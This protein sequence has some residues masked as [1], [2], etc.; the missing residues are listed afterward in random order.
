MSPSGGLLIVNADDWGYD[1]PTTEAIAECF[2]AGG[3]TS[4]T[5]MSFMAGSDFAAARARRHPRLGIGLHLNL[6][7]EYSDPKVPPAV[8]DRQKRLIEYSR[9]LRLR[10]WVYDPSSRHQVNRVIADQ[11][12]R[13]VD[14]YGRMPTHLDGHHHC[15]LAANVLISPAVPTGMKIRNALE[16]KHLRNPFT[17]GLRWMRARMISR[18]FTTTDRFLSVETFWPDLRGEV[19]ADAFGPVPSLTMEV[20]V[21]PI[22]PHEYEPLQS[23]TW[24]DALKQLPTGTFDD[25]R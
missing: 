1:E 16:N 21:H 22:F 3:L 2:E 23:S 20:M 17:D 25:L 4:T 12:Q 9:L 13:F 15:H 14:D 10:R 8:R 24:V 11:L 7:E 18:R 6:V 5:A 19:P